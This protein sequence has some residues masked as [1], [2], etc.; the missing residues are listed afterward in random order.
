[1][2]PFTWLGPPVKQNIANAGPLALLVPLLDKLDVEKIID[3]HLP[4]NPQQELSHGQVLRMLL[5]ARLCHPTALV[6]VADWAEKS[7]AAFFAN[8][9][10]D[11]LNDD[12]L[13]RALD[14]FFEHRHSILGS[15]TAQALQVTDLSLNRLHFDPTDLVFS[16]AYETSTPRLPQD[17][18]QPFNGDGRLPAA[19]ICHGYTSDR[20]MIQASQLAVV[21]N[22]GAIPVFAHCLDGNRNGHPSIRETF[23]LAQQHLSFPQTMLMISDR[24][25][26]SIEHI[27]RLNKNGY[28]ALCAAQWQEYRSL[29]ENNAD[30]LQW[31]PASF[32][33]IEQKRRRTTQSAL[34]QESYK[35]AVLNHELVDPADKKTI[36]A[37]IIFVHSSADER[38]SRA[39]RQK[40]IAKIK[41]RLEEIQ[42][43]FLRGHPQCTIASVT[44]QVDQLLGNK[45]A[46]K[47]FAWQFVPLTVEEQ[48]A[49]PAPKC[50][51]R[52]ATMRLTFTLDS[53]AAEAKQRYDGLSVLV[54]TA[55]KTQSADLLFS[56]YKQ[57]NYVEMLHH[58]WKTPL[59][60]TPVFLKSPSRIEALVCLLQIALQA[61]QV[62]ERLY[63]QQVLKE[64]ARAER[65]MTAERMLRAF[66]VYG[67]YIERTPLGNVVHTTKLTE[68][69]KQILSR[70]GFATPE[71]ILRRILEPPPCL[72]Q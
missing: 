3:R 37:R 44:R 28:S 56:Q 35:L 67:L 4:P 39:H 36:P 68:R 8:I 19:H 60:V 21:D 12:R 65:R 1:M 69:Q 59:A 26:C 2:V 23:Q 9:P 66:Q 72:K 6:N 5:A 32:L 57:Q 34:P 48:N 58:Q 27:A 63:R 47:Y 33:S 31:Q 11:K 40:N 51:H 55:P 71:E 30:R 54:T 38:D 14:A 61:Y 16:G 45:E 7:G 25:T 13:G 18:S 64:E 10:V 46:G 42:E 43:K 15:M 70:L 41:A 24:G 22:L 29:Y 62:L 52:R 17:K 20:K 53:A 49:L 50:G